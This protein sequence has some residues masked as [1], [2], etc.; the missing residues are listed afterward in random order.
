M[1]NRKNN[2]ISFGITLAP[3]N[4]TEAAN[5]DLEKRVLIVRRG[6]ALPGKT[7]QVSSQDFNLP[8]QKKMPLTNKPFT[9]D[10]F[11]CTP[12]PLPA[13]PS[14]EKMS[15]KVER[16]RKELE[17]SRSRTAPHSAWGKSFSITLSVLWE[18][19]TII[20]VGFFIA[21]KYMS[22][23]AAAIITIGCMLCAGRQTTGLR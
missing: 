22:I 4:R 13:F 7:K 16:V 8:C 10:M 3:A 14:P 19:F 15:P 11:N 9:P 18:I 6:K 20:C 1:K 5:T 2:P 17:R 12:R 21:L 23:A